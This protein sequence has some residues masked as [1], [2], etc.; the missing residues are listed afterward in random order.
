M[1]ISQGICKDRE[2]EI[3]TIVSPPPHTHSI[4]SPLHS[5]P[6]QHCSEGLEGGKQNPALLSWDRGSSGT[7]PCCLE[8]GEQ[9]FAPGAVAPPP[10]P[11]YLCLRVSPSQATK[12]YGSS[13][14]RPMDPRGG[15]E[16]GHCPLLS[17]CGAGGGTG[18]H[19][20]LSQPSTMRLPRGVCPP[21]SLPPISGAL[22]VPPTV[23]TH[24]GSAPPLPRSYTF[25]LQGSGEGGGGRGVVLLKSAPVP[26]NLPPPPYP[27]RP[28]SGAPSLT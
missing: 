2:K 4:P 10:P 5:I 6:P 12:A 9:G 28:L 7:N 19:R 27:S 22:Q 11:H 3:Y 16:G 23:G 20:S 21:P 24:V 25:G 15:R 26:I 8:G 13:R 14:K 18:H 17:L 1:V